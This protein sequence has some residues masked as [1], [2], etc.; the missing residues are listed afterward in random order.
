MKYICAFFFLVVPMV[1]F[2][3]VYY[4]CIG[5][6]GSKTYR[7]EP[8][9]KGD[10][11]VRKFS[12]DLSVFDSSKKEFMGSAD[13]RPV[14][15][16]PEQNGTYFVSGS[17]NGYPVRFVVDTGATNLTLST[18]HASAFGVVGCVLSKTATGNGLVDTCNTIA[19]AITFGG[20]SL[21][22]VPVTIA[23]NLSGE[24]L[25]GMSV[26]SQFRIEQVNGVMRVSKH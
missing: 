10:R 25:L 7:V 5:P 3:E 20:F 14:D 16:R 21:D 17:I 11:E 2:S 4:D 26:L 22:N 18:Q 15:L 12:V 1:A 24:P 13:L 8:C 19:S 9:V 6:D 23:P